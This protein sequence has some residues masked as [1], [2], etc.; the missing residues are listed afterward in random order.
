MF[1]IIW[2]ESYIS[3]ILKDAIIPSDITDKNSM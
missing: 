2:I 3:K 1:G